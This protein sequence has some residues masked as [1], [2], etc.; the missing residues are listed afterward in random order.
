MRVTGEGGVGIE[1]FV[2]GPEDGTPVLFMHGW[3]DTHDLWRHQVAALAQDGYRTIAP[4]LRG[5]GASDKP[6]DVDAYQLKN[7]VFDMLAVLDANQVKQAHIVAHDWGAAAAWGLTAFLPD[8]VHS[9]TVLSVGHPNAFRDAGF[10]QRARSWYMLLFNFEG[11]AEEWFEQNKEVMLASHPDRA[12]IVKALAEPGAL[13]ASLG[14]YRANAHPRT[15]V[16]GPLELPRVTTPVMGVWSTGDFALTEQQM[17]GSK[18]YVDGPF[19]YERVE[20]AAHW[21]QA[22]KPEEITALLRDFLP[23]HS[24]SQ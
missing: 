6:Q 23:Q 22:E 15:L 21:M 7:T 19:R 24:P 2:D 5:F 4:D 1:V 11:I 8:H 17:T 9:L 16:S 13:T 10:E 3:P 20:G 12:D 14:W 18:D